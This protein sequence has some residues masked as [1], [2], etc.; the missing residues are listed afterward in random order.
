MSDWDCGVAALPEGKMGLNT[1]QISL[2][3]RQ[4]LANTSQ[5]Q[6]LVDSFRKSTI[7]L[8]VLLFEG[9]IWVEIEG[10]VLI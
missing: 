6:T 9:L 7:T 4:V 10:P 3:E 8:F 1:M 2:V 5:I